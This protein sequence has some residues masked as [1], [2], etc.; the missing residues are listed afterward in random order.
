MSKPE[1]ASIHLG[2]EDGV[3][4]D[5]HAG[6]GDRQVALIAQ[7][8]RTALIA[9]VGALACGAL[10]ENL[11]LAVPA[12]A[13]QPGT[14]LRFPGGALLEVTGART[15]CVELEQVARGLL[16]AAVGRCGSFATVRRGGLVTPGDRVTPVMATTPRP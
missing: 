11:V 9:Q 5:V 12:R 16:R 2:V 15:P 13:L 7:E 14:L 1:A 8:T 10:G 4:G 3:V 6:P